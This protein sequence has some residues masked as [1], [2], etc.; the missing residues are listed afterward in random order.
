MDQWK[1]PFFR[2]YWLRGEAQRGKPNGPGSR[3]VARL[4]PTKLRKTHARCV[5]LTSM[6]AETGHS[7]VRDLAYIRRPKSL[8]GS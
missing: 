3:E 2:S 5:S 7:F 1:G 4:G 8:G 6:S